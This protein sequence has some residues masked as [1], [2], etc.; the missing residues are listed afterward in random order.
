MEVS[1]SSTSDSVRLV[2][3]RRVRYFSRFCSSKV[4]GVL[5]SFLAIR[6]VSS[7]VTIASRKV[8]SYRTVILVIHAIR[9]RFKRN[10]QKIAVAE[11]F[12]KISAFNL[13]IYKYLLYLYI[14]EEFQVNMFY[15]T[16]MSHKY[17]NFHKYCSFVYHFLSVKEYSLHQSSVLHYSDRRIY[18]RRMIE[19]YHYFSCL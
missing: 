17:C 15:V 6:H 19:G 13:K 7:S 2:A 14:L 8:L 10:S 16:L 1:F 3:K 4:G 9:T 18:K 12:T 5:R 11:S